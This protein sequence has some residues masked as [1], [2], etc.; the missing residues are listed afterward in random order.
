MSANVL[1]MSARKTKSYPQPAKLKTV[2]VFKNNIGMY[3][4]EK[5]IEFVFKEKCLLISGGP[6]KTSP[7]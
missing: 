7:V 6:K 3:L 2:S 1:K 4:K 5:K